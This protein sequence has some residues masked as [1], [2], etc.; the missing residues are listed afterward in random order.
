MVNMQQAQ[1]KLKMKVETES[2]LVR[3]PSQPVASAVV[4]AVAV[5]KGTDGVN[6]ITGK[7]VRLN[8]FVFT[9][10]HLGTNR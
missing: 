10:A 8:S 9:M 4:V 1:T 7:V 6:E 2:E 5:H 3:Q